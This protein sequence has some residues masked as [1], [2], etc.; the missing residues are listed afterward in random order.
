MD[1]KYIRLLIDRCLNFKKSNILFISYDKVN[2]DF[3]LDVVKYA[4]KRV[5]M[6]YI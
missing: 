6:I 4:K 2:K 1:D 3:V 5:L